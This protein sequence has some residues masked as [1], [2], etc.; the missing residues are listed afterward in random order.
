M[1]LGVAAA[2]ALAGGI[3]FAVASKSGGGTA[4]PAAGHDHAAHDHDAPS[5][6]ESKKADKPDPVEPAAKPAEHVEA[7]VEP[8]TPPPVEPK[9]EAKVE[10]VTPP[11][12]DPPVE[13]VTPPPA[14][15]E[16]P[17][18]TAAPVKKKSSSK[19]S[20]GKKKVGT[21]KTGGDTGDDDLSNSRY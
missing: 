11:P 20:T 14:E 7:K 6:R 19:K 16:D 12:V 2:V 18:A 8:V 3:A 1:I 15:V 4:E 9:V 13:P 21:K 10:P 5:G 17:V